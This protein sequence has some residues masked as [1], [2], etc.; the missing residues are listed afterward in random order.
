[1]VLINIISGNYIDENYGL[2]Y[3]MFSKEAKKVGPLRH[4]LVLKLAILKREK[5]LGTD[6]HVLVNQTKYVSEGLENVLTQPITGKGASSI[7]RPVEEEEASNTIKLED[8]A[9]LVSNVEPSF[10]DINSPE[11]DHVIIVDDS[12]ED[13]EDEVHPTLNA[14]NEDTPVP[15]S[16]SPKSSQIQK[17]T[18]Q[19][20]IL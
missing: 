15:K 3:S 16:S 19:V 12:D 1:M 6:P 18:N 14:T 4:L 11:D 5:S 2:L 9:K 20:L 17:L 13:E 7:A 8:L 10:K